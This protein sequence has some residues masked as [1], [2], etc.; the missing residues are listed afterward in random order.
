MLQPGQRDGEASPKFAGSDPHRTRGR[1]A[2]EGTPAFRKALTFA[3]R[4]RNEGLGQHVKPSTAST[5]PQGDLGDKGAAVGGAAEDPPGF[6]GSGLATHGSARQVH[7]KGRPRIARVLCSGSVGPRR[8]LGQLAGGG[9]VFAF[10]PGF[11]GS[12]RLARLFRKGLTNMAQ[13]PEKLMG[14]ARGATGFR[15]GRESGA[16]SVL[17]RRVSFAEV[18]RRRRSKE[19]RIPRR[20]LAKPRRGRGER[21]SR[22]W[23]KIAL[24]ARHPR[25]LGVETARSA[26]RGCERSHGDN[27]P[28][29]GS[30]CVQNKRV[31]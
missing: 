11:R 27:A 29:T 14:L 4:R 22:P 18:D 28:T 25:V 1:L 9:E 7:E 21:G 3:G 17:V 13:T 6:R 31:R 20:T 23:M 12:L 16:R 8:S 2:V 5:P 30:A 26:G 10:S 24:R 15:G 19:A